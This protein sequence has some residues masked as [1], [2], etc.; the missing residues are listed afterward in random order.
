[1]VRYRPCLS[2]ALYSIAVS[3]YG[4]IYSTR[5]HVERQIQHEAKPSAVFISR[6]A[7]SAIFFVYTSLGDALSGTY[8][9]RILNY[10]CDVSYVTL[11]AKTSLVRT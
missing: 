10:Y 8:I 5:W 1:M 7:P 11:Q 6:H 2:D 4:N 3:V 9:V